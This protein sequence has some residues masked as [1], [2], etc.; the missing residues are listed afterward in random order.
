MD[1]RDLDLDQDS[2]RRRDGNVCMD[3]QQRGASMNAAVEEKYWP[4]RRERLLFWER[5]FDFAIS[6]ADNRFRASSPGSSRRPCDQLAQLADRKPLGIDVDV[7][8]EIADGVFERGQ[9]GPVGRAEPIPE[10]CGNRRLPVS[11]QPVRKDSAVVFEDQVSDAEGFAMGESARSGDQG[12]RNCAEDGQ[13]Q[14]I[15][16]DSPPGTG[17]V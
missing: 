11:W 12:E 7:L 3:K 16:H 6:G 17:L 2:R 4:G 10:H 8:V 15:P 1:T 13:K 5:D 14:A 9:M